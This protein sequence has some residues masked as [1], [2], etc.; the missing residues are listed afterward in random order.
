M[1]HFTLNTIVYFIKFITALFL[2]FI[3][4]PRLIFV[5]N[6]EDI[7]ESLVMNFV[8]L[9]F[10]TV[11]LGYVL[12]WSRLF[13]LITI[14]AIMAVAAV[15]KFYKR[16]ISQGE[17]TNAISDDVQILVIN[18]VERVESIEGK[19]LVWWEK[20]M[21]RFRY[22]ISLYFGDIWVFTNALL[23]I[24]VFSYSAYLSF[25]DSF[26]YVS[27]PDSEGFITLARTKYLEHRL[28]FYDGIYPQ[29][30]YLLL[31]VIRKFAQIDPM[32]VVKFSVPAFGLITCFSMYF[33]VSRIS[34]CSAAG[35]IP[36]VVFGW[37]GT[38]FL[39]EYALV[40][41][42]IVPWASVMLA[43]MTMYLFY[44]Y[45]ENCEKRY[46]LSAA[47]GA[48]AV[49]LI[50]PFGFVFLVLGV[51]TL[52]MAILL[53]DFVKS[54]LKVLKMAGM[55]AAAGLIAATPAGVGMLTGS[56][57]SNAALEVIANTPFKAFN[58]GLYD[59]G[60]L[61]G[62]GLT[63][64]H[65][66]VSIRNR[67]GFAA[68]IW[69]FSLGT[70][71]FCLTYFSW[72]LG[73]GYAAAGAL[74]LWRIMIPVLIGFGAGVVFSAFNRILK[75]KNLGHVICAVI[76][77]AMVVFYP[78]KPSLAPRGEINTLVEQYLKI[79]TVYRP[80]QWVMVSRGEGFALAYGSGYHILPDEFVEKFSPFQSKLTDSSG[81]LS[82]TLSANYI[83]VFNEKTDK[84]SAA[85]TRE[86]I[87]DWLEKYKNYH[88][89][90]TLYYSDDDF[91]IWKIQ[92]E[93]GRDE[94]IEG[95]WRE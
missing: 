66:F 56:W 53:S 48:G 79:R 62:L 71:V 55:V 87:D 82:K 81:P 30:F 78:Q 90:I 39:G 24:L 88:N 16:R 51:I 13:E 75:T 5:Y 58:P 85:G 35:I 26:C 32:Y 7:T 65:A 46:F 91:D 74:L 43:F 60:A 20:R 84:A 12:V 80:T 18:H 19:L 76:C 33:F 73:N 42:T 31:A 69:V 2:L 37:L 41:S 93:P 68:K 6:D 17:K 44:K 9:V 77:T 83:F 94:V 72:W 4:A 29:G 57:F 36:A 25:Y 23:L 54:I 38:H 67:S 27:L 40:G 15:Y 52:S 8:K 34:G 89:N 22:M 14:L 61:A 50:H 47:L 64:L 92:Q 1:N 49:G 10:W 11:A 95:I 28:M 63:L 21:D 86:K 59:Y 70:S 3:V 45:T